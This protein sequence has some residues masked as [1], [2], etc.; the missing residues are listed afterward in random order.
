[1]TVE[2]TLFTTLSEDSNVSAEVTNST[3]PLTYRIYPNVA[4]EN[5]SVPYITYLVVDTVVPVVFNDITNIE[6]SRIQVDVWHNTALSASQ[7][8]DHVVNAVNGSTMALG[9]VFKQSLYDDEIKLHRYSI[10][11]LVWD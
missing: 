3:S 7:L 4:D 9:E 6:R 2:Q 1:M 5:V 8:A 10:D 11:L